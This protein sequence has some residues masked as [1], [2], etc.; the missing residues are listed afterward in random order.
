MSNEHIKVFLRIRPNNPNPNFIHL[1][2]ESNTA[3][4]KVDIKDKIRHDYINNSKEKYFF[5]FN[6]V[7]NQHTQ[8]D[9]IFNEIAKEVCDSAL[10]GYNGTI[11]AY[12]QTGSGKTYTITGGVERVEQ[13]G[14]IPRTLSYLFQQMRERSN[15]KYTI[16]I[17]YLEI[18]NNEGFDLLVDS[19]LSTGINRLEDLPKVI[20]RENLDK[21]LLLYNLSSHT[22][23]NETEAL[24]YLMKGDDNRVIAETPKNDASTR[25]HCIFMIQ[26][27]ALTDV[28][29]NEGEVNQVR[30]VSKLHIVD[31]SGSEKAM[32]SNLNNE[33]FH[34]ATNINLSLHYLGHVISS[35]NKNQIHIPY[36]NTMMTMILRDSLGGNCKTRM[37]ATCSGMI[38]DIHES[39]STCR[40]AQSVSLVKNI[41]S[42]NEVED[43]ELVIKKQ[44]EEIEDLKNELKV[45]KGIDTK[46]FLDEDDINQCK[47]RVEEYLISDSYEKIGYK[48]F[49]MLDECIKQM[50]MKYK[51]LE[52]EIKSKENKEKDIKSTEICSICN[53]MK[54]ENEKLKG[55][56]KQMKE[57]IKNKEKEMKGIVNFYEKEKI[58]TER[59]NSLYQK[60]Q[61]EDEK[62]KEKKSIMES[63]RKNYIGEEVLF[64]NDKKEEKTINSSQIMNNINTSSAS[65]IQNGIKS[66][67]PI[68]LLTEINRVNSTLK[69]EAIE[70]Q[71]EELTLNIIQDSK[72]SYDYF[73][74]NYLKSEIH[75]ENLN[76]LKVL[77]TEGKALSGT[78]EEI[79]R[80]INSIKVRIEE[81]KKEFKARDFDEV[82]RPPIEMRKL[83]DDLY[84][85]MK[86]NK[87]EYE[88]NMSI[89]KRHKADI[90]FL[91]SLVEENTT[92]LSKDF[93]QWHNVMIK[94][95]EY[96]M[97]NKI[98]LTNDF[99]LKLNSKGN[100]QLNMSSTIEN[101]S[102][103][104][105]SQE[106]NVNKSTNSSSK[107]LN[108][109]MSLLSQAKG[110]INKNNK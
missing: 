12:G 74:K 57:V 58:T 97:K 91:N 92:K 70:R 33:R 4:F 102:V 79:R 50:K 108:D 49:L 10:E 2:E 18:Y 15:T 1:Y 86:E 31:L 66:N 5:K 32:K 84:T 52:N 39:I 110:I 8:Q 90:D 46:E 3:E 98:N 104:Y 9:V 78:N 30:T 103:N 107:A 77:F 96:E 60:I 45:I 51:T 42:K 94:K 106:R 34:E 28:I 88:K 47:V 62:E 99:S 25:S 16:R 24:I 48:D 76:R 83:E 61:V 6:K 55:E 17:S 82:N 14:I 19:P 43:P 65:I 64:G 67:I 72:L 36:R 26:L 71:S 7:F 89:L 23:N 87:E 75:I 54:I 41:I 13:R 68:S 44:R 22:V 105:G 109:V 35:I 56:I 95:F 81:L 11:F 21:Q 93:S 80:K 63:I 59:N 29:S 40:F 38:D 20:M 100:N 69:Q 27:E 37:I 85:Q 53:E 73:K 101:T